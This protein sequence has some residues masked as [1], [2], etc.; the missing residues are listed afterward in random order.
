[1]NGG[2]NQAVWFLQATEIFF[3]FLTVVL[4]RFQT[5]QNREW[6]PQVNLS[7]YELGTQVFGSGIRAADRARVQG[8][9][10]SDHL[11]PQVPQPSVQH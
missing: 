9:G 7:A 8:Q 3:F 6:W 10:P 5:N 1:M 4:F 11:G 2:E